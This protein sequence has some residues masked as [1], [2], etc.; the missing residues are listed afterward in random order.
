[1][2]IMYRNEQGKN[3]PVVYKGASADG[4]IHTARLEI[5]MKMTVHDSNLQL[6]NQPNFSNIP[7][8]PL[9]YR[10]EVGTGLSLEEAQA[11]ARPQTIPPVQQDLMSWH[12]Q[13]YHLPYHILFRLESIGTPTKRL[14]ECR[15]KPRYVWHVNSAK[16]IVAL[17]GLKKRRAALYGN[18]NKRTR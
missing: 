4:L 7:K 13:L 11:L 9:D 8:T 5:G 1:M 6:L 10:N 18:R 3:L 16:R 12:H 15:K 2:D 17:G 14:P